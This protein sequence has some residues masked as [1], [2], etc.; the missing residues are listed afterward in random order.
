[1]SKKTRKHHKT[2]RCKMPQECKKYVKKATQLKCLLKSCKARK[3]ASVYGVSKG[4]TI[5][6]RIEY[7]SN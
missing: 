7:P 5:R 1:M 4:G 3:Y 6:S 2:P